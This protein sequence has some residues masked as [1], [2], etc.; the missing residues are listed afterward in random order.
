MDKV[1]PNGEPYLKP[2]RKKGT[3]VNPD[4]TLRFPAISSRPTPQQ[5]SAAPI[6]PCAAQ[7]SGVELVNNSLL[8][9]LRGQLAQQTAMIDHLE[10]ENSALKKTITEF[11]TAARVKEKELQG[12]MKIRKNTAALYRSIAASN[13]QGLAPEDFSEVSPLKIPAVP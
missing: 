10:T 3:S 2:G 7:A 5:V 11:A 13:L 6:T 4:G 12:E 1:K 9:E 8:E